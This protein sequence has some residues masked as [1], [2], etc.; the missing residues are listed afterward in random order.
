MILIGSEFVM[1][2]SFAFILRNA[3]PV[4]KANGI[5]T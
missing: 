3:S 2:S 1:S 4:L 5:T